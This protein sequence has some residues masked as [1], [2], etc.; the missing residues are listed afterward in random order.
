MPDNCGFISSLRTRLLGELD[1]HLITIALKLAFTRHE[2]LRTYFRAEN[3][4]VVQEVLPADSFQ[5]VLVE[6]GGAAEAEAWLQV[7]GAQP[8]DLQRGPLF[9]AALLRLN[10]RDYILAMSA[11]QS[12]VD[13][14]SWRLILAD[15]AV[16][17]SAA[18]NGSM[19]ELSPPPIQYADFAV[20]QREQ[21]S[22]PRLE[23][24]LSH[25]RKVLENAP[26]VLEI[27][28][29]RPQSAGSRPVAAVHRFDAGNTVAALRELARREG[30]TTAMVL[31]AAFQVLLARWASQGDV[32]TGIP[33]AGRTR[34]ELEETVGLFENML[35]LRTQIE[36]DPTFLE[37]LAQV[38]ASMLD[39]YAHQ[40]LPFERLVEELQVERSLTHEP[41]F[42][43]SF[44]YLEALPPVLQIHGLE[45]HP[46]RSDPEVA[47]YAL[48]LEM[49][50]DG[51]RLEGTILYDSTLLDLATVSRAADRL[52]R[53]V[54]LAVSQPEM[55]P[56]SAPLLGE[57]EL[58]MLRNWS[59]GA[60][61]TKVPFVSLPAMFEAQA[62]L[63]PAAPAIHFQGST[64]TYGELNARANHI[65]HSLSV[66]GVT[67][68]CRVCICLE[69]TPDAVAA[70]LGVM[71]AGAAYVPLSPEYPA[72]R[73]AYILVDTQAAALVTTSTLAPVRADGVPTLL[74]DLQEQRIGARAPDTPSFKVE[75]DWVAY[76]IYTSGS[77]GRPK[78]VMIEHGSV[79]M[80][81]T[82]LASSITA[83]ERSSVLAFTPFPFDVSVAE[84]FSTLCFGGTLVLVRGLDELAATM[85]AKSIRLAFLVPVVAGLMSENLL[86]R[87]LH[88]LLIAGEPLS[89]TLSE[90][91]FQTGTVRE[92]I[93]LYGPTEATVYAT[94]SAVR[95]GDGDPPIGCPMPGRSAYVLDEARLPVPIGVPGELYLGGAGLARG[96]LVRPALTA[97][98]FIPD[99]FS[100]EPGTRMYRT[101]DRVRWRADG[102]LEYL[103]RLDFQVKVRGFRIEPGEVESVLSSHP[104]IRDA[105]VAAVASPE[106]GRVL[107][108]YVVA[109]GPPNVSGLR[110]FLRGRLPDYMVPSA[111]VQLDAFPLTP[112]GKVDRRALPA[113]DQPLSL[114]FTS[115]V[116]E[117]ERT[118]AA[119][120]ADVLKVDQV[121]AGDDFF[122][123]G[124]HS[125]LAVQ[126]I[127][128]VAAHFGVELSLR[129]FFEAADLRGFSARVDSAV[130]A[131]LAELS[132]DYGLDAPIIR[133][134]VT[135]ISPDEDGSLP[136]SLDLH[137][138]AGRA[139]LNRDYVLAVTIRRPRVTGPPPGPIDVLL[140]CDEHINLLSPWQREI[141]PDQANGPGDRVS[142]L[143][144]P[145]VEGTGWLS[146]IF[147]VAGRWSGTQTLRVPCV[148]ANELH[149]HAS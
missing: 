38:R 22:G 72:E 66:L 149:L 16:A 62:A 124:G 138:D 32:V 70:M 56:R 49:H 59:R 145:V 17:Y 82:T 3:G 31:L 2:A 35:P 7:E 50:V 101:G 116:T 12:V 14:W 117:T 44:S 122:A 76:V 147:Y 123:L 48:A 34:A 104:Q 109:D 18:A 52:T 139:H 135:G 102:E 94:W 75:S 142:F 69:R 41:V 105:V 5:F 108:A 45:S 119:I 27:P 93:N 1:E 64:T 47:K 128:R 112:S 96:Y 130:R 114:K 30:V 28:T 54:G 129:S 9:R 58:A 110:E 60:S 80:L 26:G 61:V 141:V 133:E 21:L 42:Q 113:P 144:R 120:W 37:V 25:W 86:P 11:H 78:G 107:T 40:E 146:V 99:P 95:A 125:I 90:R 23:A 53:L 103:G 43:V 111:I 98:R 143:I 65:A 83:E 126:V 88:R 67:P 20:W 73:N 29:D 118:V 55:R 97:E 13:N 79:S 85:A 92:I 77:T 106:G 115:P 24:E 87:T 71:K 89:S 131:Y 91:L 140:T 134:E 6:I 57:A 100:D 51:D 84:L 19:P 15:V 4:A 127:A 137:L 136:V 10:S 8:F 132:P 33:V 74:L 39:A 121:G 63:Q 36:G 148:P 81:L 46:L 68:G